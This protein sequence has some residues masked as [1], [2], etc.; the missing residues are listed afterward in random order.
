MN[1]INLIV[2]ILSV[3]SFGTIVFFV[4]KK[5]DKKDDSIS[6]NLKI[7][8]AKVVNTENAGYRSG[9][10]RVYVEYPFKG[11]IY[12]ADFAKSHTD[13]DL[14]SKN[15]PLVIDSLDNNNSY[16]LTSSADFRK[17]GIEFPDSL[18]WLKE[19]FRP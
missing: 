14:L 8:T 6:K 19:C 4:N 2:V 1:K 10:L 7:V 16:L 18:K 15:I 3:L 5:H 17:F 9:S 12:K 13:C 11:K